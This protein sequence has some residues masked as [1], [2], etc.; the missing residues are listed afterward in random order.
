M[1]CPQCNADAYSL[2]TRTRQDGVVRRRYLCKSDHRFTTL[3]AYVNDTET[4]V[5]TKPQA[6]ESSGR[7]GLSALW[8]RPHGRR[9]LI[10]TWRAG[11][12]ASVKADDNLIAALC[13]RCHYEIDQGKTLDKQE[14]QEMW[15]AA[16]RRTV[17]KLVALDL[18]PS[19]IKIPDAVA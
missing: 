12:A 6:T 5:R 17:D 11:A 1:K 16:H 15:A 9:R 13:L 2:E 4:Q 14:R 3:E 7:L 8:I 18:W 19:N 10:V